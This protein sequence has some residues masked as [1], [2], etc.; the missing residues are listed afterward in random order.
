MLALVERRDACGYNPRFVF[1]KIYVAVSVV[2]DGG[3]G[4]ERVARL[5]LE[6]ALEDLSAGKSFSQESSSGG[7]RSDWWTN[8]CQH[9]SFLPS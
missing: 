6:Q 3:N 8:N 7:V 5:D 9:Q 1:C 2:A 4:A